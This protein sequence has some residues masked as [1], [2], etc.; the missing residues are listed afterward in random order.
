[1]HRAQNVFD[2]RNVDV[3]VV[4]DEAALLCQVGGPDVMQQQREH[5]RVLARKANVVMR[6]LTLDSGARAAT[7]GAFTLLE[8][9]DPKEPDLAYAETYLAGQYSVKTAVLAEL[10]WTYDRLVAQSVH[11]EEYER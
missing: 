1:M 8:F 10:R 7:R 5:L 3:S 9:N 6:V 2:R 4:V 11:L